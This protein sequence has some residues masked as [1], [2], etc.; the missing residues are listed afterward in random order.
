M[1]TDRANVAET[2]SKVDR[3]SSKPGIKTLKLK[4]PSGTS[5]KRSFSFRCQYG[6]SQP[7]TNLY[8]NVICV[9]SSAYPSRNDREWGKGLG[10]VEYESSQ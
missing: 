1:Q 5:L 10:D 2:G 9:I 8:Y 3:S 6:D 4:H 7:V